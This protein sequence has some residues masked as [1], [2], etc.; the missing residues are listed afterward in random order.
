MQGVQNAFSS[1]QT[2][3]FA[4]YMVNFFETFSTQNF[5]SS[6]QDPTDVS[7]KKT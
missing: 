7:Q 1:F 5:S 6:K 3:Q 2:L 4:I